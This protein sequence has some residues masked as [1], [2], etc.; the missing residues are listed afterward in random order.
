MDSL[1]VNELIEVL[2]RDTINNKIKWEPYQ[3]VDYCHQRINGYKYKG[4]HID[5]PGNDKS[6]KFY[7]KRFGI[8]TTYC[9]YV[10]PSNIETYANI[11]LINLHMDERVHNEEKSESNNYITKVF[12]KLRLI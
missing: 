10:Y 1:D 2:R 5:E 9:K 4:L 3:Y 11:I 7:F 12:R 8:I 6:F